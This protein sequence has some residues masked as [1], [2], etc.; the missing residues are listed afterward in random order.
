MSRKGLKLAVFAL[1][2][3]GFFDRPSLYWSIAPVAL[4]V[5]VMAGGGLYLSLGLGS[6]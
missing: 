1:F 3:L 4:L 2:L 6:G 5:E